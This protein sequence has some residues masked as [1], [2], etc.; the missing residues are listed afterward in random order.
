[1]P[2]LQI[3]SDSAVYRHYKGNLYELLNTAVHTETEEK[4]AVYRSVEQPDKIWARPYDMF[5]DTVVVD[6]KKI[7]R[8]EQVNL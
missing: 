2:S 5:V 6:G 4:L 1:M 3:N 8:F 7:P